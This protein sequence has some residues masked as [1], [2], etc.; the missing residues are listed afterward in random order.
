MRGFKMDG[1]SAKIRAVVFGVRSHKNVTLFVCQGT[2]LKM[3]VSAAAMLSVGLEQVTLTRLVRFENVVRHHARSS[4]YYS[5]CSFANTE[6][7]WAKM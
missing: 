5:N 2:S 3:L 1:L 6:Q 7:F 4:L